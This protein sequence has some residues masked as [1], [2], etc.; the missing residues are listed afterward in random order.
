MLPGY[1]G[2]GWRNVWLGVTAEDQERYEQRW[3]ILQRL[4]A[5][6]RFVSYEPAI[7]P[8]R[9]DG[10]RLP[11][12]VITGGESGA[13]ARVCDPQWIRDAVADCERQGVAVFHK[14]WGSYRSNPLVFEL[15]LTPY[16]AE[17]RD[18]KE[19]GKGGALLDGRL[20]RQFPESAG[21]QMT[22]CGLGT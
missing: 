17:R 4:P 10:E 14:Q 7:G 8:L 3:R 19:N 15:G 11:D 20:W 1:W 16:E 2:D 13:G 12:W 21:E 9:I 5:A 6:I 22:L 18:P